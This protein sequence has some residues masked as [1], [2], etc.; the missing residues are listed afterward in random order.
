MGAPFSSIR[1][2]FAADLQRP[3]GECAATPPLLPSARERPAGKARVLKL[4]PEQVRGK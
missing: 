4:H 3:R 2:R 1:E